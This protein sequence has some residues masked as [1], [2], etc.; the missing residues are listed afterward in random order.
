MGG[1]NLS[2]IKKILWFTI[3]LRAHQFILASRFSIVA[4]YRKS[5]QIEFPHVQPVLALDCVRRC[6]SCDSGTQSEGECVQSK[7]PCAN[8]PGLQGMWIP[9][10]SSSFFFTRLRWAHGCFEWCHGLKGRLAHVHCMFLQLGTSGLLVIM[11]TVIFLCH[12]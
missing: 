12:F 6:H 5:R 7:Y 3:Q 4:R 10:L 2:C 1:V 11:I 8:V 9:P